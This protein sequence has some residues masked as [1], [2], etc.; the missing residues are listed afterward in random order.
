MATPIGTNVVTSLSRRYIMPE[1]VDVVY[2]SNPFT[3][4]L[5][6]S[7]RKVIQGSTQIEW[8]MMYKRFTN[9]GSFSGYQV[10]DIAPNDTIK[11]AAVDWKQKYVPVTV[12]DLTLIKTDSP[13]AIANFIKQYFAQAEEEM[14]ELMAAGLFSDTVTDPNEIDGL[15]GIVDAGSVATTYGGLTRASNTFLNSQVDSTTTTLTTA[16]LQSFFM[17]VKA[18]GRVPTIIL[19]RV[20][21]YNR[22]HNLGMVNQLFNLGPTGSNEQLLAAGF[23][24]LL[25]NNTPWVEDSHVFDGANSSNS[26]ILMLNEDYLNLAVSPRADFAM[27]DFVRPVDQMAM[28]AMIYWAGNLFCTNPQRQGKA[29]AIVA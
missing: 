22:Y 6:Q 26:A 24:N 10:L 15:E 1:I 13:Q 18:G 19:S 5:L 14:A 25:Y 29:T 16:F 20:E 11:N 21:Q 9:G 17:T 7:N 28:T 4:R 2:Q 8:P 12:D 23:T 3:Y 27:Q